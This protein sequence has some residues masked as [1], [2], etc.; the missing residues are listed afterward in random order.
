MISSRTPEGEPNHCP[1]CDATV[2]IEHSRLFG[3]ATCP[4]C[5]TLLWYFGSPNDRVLVENA[6]SQPVRES[7]IETLARQLGVEPDQIKQK[8]PRWDDCD[9]LDM[10]ELVMEIEEH[11]DGSQ[12]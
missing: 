12:P 9:S 3:D 11:F 10:V 4:Q 8:A 5:G 2:C 7:V 6:Q 1:V